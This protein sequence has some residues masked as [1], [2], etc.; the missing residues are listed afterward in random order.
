MFRCL[1]HKQ[2]YT[3]NEGECAACMNITTYSQ[4]RLREAED[5]RK[6]REDLEAERTVSQ[7]Q[8]ASKKARTVGATKKAHNN[9]KK[10]G[11]RG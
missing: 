1:V 5:S 9:T 4:K 11:K 7:E 8:R 10:F 6:Q 3:K 2:K